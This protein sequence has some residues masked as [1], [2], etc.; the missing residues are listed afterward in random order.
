MFEQVDQVLL[1]DAEVLKIKLTDAME[2]GAV[3]ELDP[4]EAEAA[5]A[6]SEDALGEAEA[7]DSQCDLLELLR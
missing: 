3:V 6:F 4:Y 7:L 2:P 1:F 5:G